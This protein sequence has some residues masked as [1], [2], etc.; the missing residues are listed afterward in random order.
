[1]QDAFL[2][3]WERWDR[4]SQL[5]DPVGYLYRTAMNMFKKRYRRLTLALRRAVAQSPP[6]DPFEEIDEQQD[7]IDALSQLSP[8]PTCRV[9]VA[10]RR[11]YDLRGGRTH[12]GRCPWDGPRTRDA[13]SICDP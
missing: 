6:R 11:G 8:A 3:I 13:G 1:M 4:V 12:A 9:G 10:R 2:A 5:E 7:L